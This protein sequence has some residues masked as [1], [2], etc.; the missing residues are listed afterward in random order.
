MTIRTY[1]RVALAHTG[2]L[3]RDGGFALQTESEVA[4]FGLELAMQSYLIALIGCCLLDISLCLER[5]R[6]PS[7]SFYFAG[8][9]TGGIIRGTRIDGMI[10][11][12]EEEVVSVH[13]ITTSCVARSLALAL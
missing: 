13:I 3:L 10:S 12:H 6:D 1:L 7:A 11:R 9:L 4:A 5:L 8:E 2:T